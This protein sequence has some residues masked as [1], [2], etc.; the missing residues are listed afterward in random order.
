[1][2]DQKAQKPIQKR[3]TATKAGG[4]VEKTD[5]EGASEEEDDRDDEAL[6]PPLKKVT[7]CM[8]LPCIRGF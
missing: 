6:E 7:C 5:T 3:N 8:H 1:M 4:D 2:G